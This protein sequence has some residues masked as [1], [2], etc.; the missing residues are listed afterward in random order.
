MDFTV[1]CSLLFQNF[2]NSH[3]HFMEVEASSVLFHRLT[4]L[5][6]STNNIITYST[7][8]VEIRTH[9]V[10]NKYQ[11]CNTNQ[12]DIRFLKKSVLRL[13]LLHH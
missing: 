8:T 5:T 10:H 6:P 3:T 7:G 9:L 4:M 12:K 11:I 13:F 1:V 2:Q